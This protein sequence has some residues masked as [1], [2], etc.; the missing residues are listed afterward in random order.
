MTQLKMFLAIIFDCFLVSSDDY[1]CNVT[2]II[3]CTSHSC[4]LI[5]YS[6]ENS[7]EVCQQC[8]TNEYLTCLSRTI[9]DPAY[10]NS[11]GKC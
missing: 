7:V 6:I 5:T 8:S 9:D 4:I 11:F 1:K 10:F 2:G 3:K